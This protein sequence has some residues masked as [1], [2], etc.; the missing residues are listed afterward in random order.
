MKMEPIK[1]SETSAFST[2]TPGRCPKEDAL[3]IKHGESLKSRINQPFG[4]KVNKTSN[5]ERSVIFIVCLCIFIVSAGT[6]RLPWL[7]F[8]RA[9]SSVVRQMPGYNPERQGTARTLPE[10]LCCS[11]YC[12]FCVFLCI[13]CVHMCTVYC[14]QVATQMQLTNISYHLLAVELL[15]SM[16]R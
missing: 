6:L 12:L 10:F 8:S 9:F 13:F 14:H 2:Q 11:M 5:H 3:H 15:D 16:P 4:Q 7:R 1:C